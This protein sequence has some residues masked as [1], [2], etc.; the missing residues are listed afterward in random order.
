MVVNIAIKKR[1]KKPNSPFKQ[2]TNSSPIPLVLVWVAG[3]GGVQ[4]L[5][6]VAWGVGLDTK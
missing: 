1:E 5:I 3:L 4:G 6:T 2:W